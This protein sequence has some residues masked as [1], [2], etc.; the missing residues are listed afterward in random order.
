MVEL[1]RRDVDF[2]GSF[3]KFTLLV[4]DGKARCGRIETSHGD[5]ET[6]VFMPVGT[7]ANVKLMTPQDLLGMGA[8][9]IL[10]NSY[11]L[12]LRPG[13][14]VVKSAGGLHGFM[15]WPRAIL[16]D[17]GGFQVFSLAKMRKLSPEGVEFQSHID[18]SYHTFTPE[19]VVEIQEALGSD[20]MMPLDEC[21]P[22]PCS[23]DQAE[24]GLELTIQWAKRSL[25]ARRGRDQALFAISQG[26]MF[27]DL[28]E[29]G[30][31]ELT[32]LGFDGFALGGLSV[33]EPKD[34]LN[35]MLEK[36]VFKLPKQAPRYLM[37]VGT[38]E[39]LWEGIGA[40]VDMF[41]CV[42]PTRNARNGTVFTGKGRVN[43]KN[44]EHERSQE[45]LDSACPCY[46]CR[47]FT[48]AYL[49]HLVHSNELLGMRLATLHNL[50]FMLELVRSIRTAIQEKRFM[51]AKQEF[52]T[53]YSRGNR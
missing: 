40:G 27:E 16:T 48:R 20:M 23:R 32:K 4:E 10:G 12:Y 3:L 19:K 44:A 38:P 43:L 5:V 2:V 9:I 14:E 28:R 36:M 1:R 17:S 22:Y 18:G 52:M 21:V 29:A 50:T 45:P 33:G 15:G 41:D 51:S 7:L 46:T 42:L 6:P 26:G 35:G 8:E 24:R 11:H 39:D 31:Q 13:T 37:G 34:V 53:K 25:E 30:I 49:R 47:T